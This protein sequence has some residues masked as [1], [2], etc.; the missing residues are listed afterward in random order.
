M[1]GYVCTE[2]PETL[3]S[4]TLVSN[5]LVSSIGVQPLEMYSQWNPV[6]FGFHC[7]YIWP[8]ASILLTWKHFKIAT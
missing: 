7:L 5:I 3:V 2:C 4:S 1:Q 8:K 6:A